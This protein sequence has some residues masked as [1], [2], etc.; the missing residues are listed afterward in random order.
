M[1]C[2]TILFVRHAADGSQVKKSSQKGL[3]KP[4]EIQWTKESEISVAIDRGTVVISANRES[5][6]SLAGQLAALA[7]E[8]PGSHIHY[9][10]YNSFE[11]GSAEMI[12]G[13][14]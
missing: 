3:G 5:L 4:L 1:R 13:K 9:D 11:V 2:K 7:E 8:S 14:M 6:L 10:A 12:I